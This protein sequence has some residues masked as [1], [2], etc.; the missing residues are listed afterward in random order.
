MLFHVR[1]LVVLMNQSVVTGPSIQ[2]FTH[3]LVTI[4]TL[5]NAQHER[6]QQ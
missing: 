5:D 6:I 2:M 4:Q 1:T 3:K